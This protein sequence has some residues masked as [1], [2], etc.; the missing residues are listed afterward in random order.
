MFYRIGSADEYLYH[1][2]SAEKLLKYILPSRSLRMG[3]FAS[4]ND[5]RETKD[6]VFGFGRRAGPLDIEEIRKLGSA[7][8]KAAKS[9]AKVICFVRDASGGVGMEPNA[10]YERGFCRPRMW[11][12]YAQNHTGACLV[13]DSKMLRQALAESVSNPRDLFEQHV[14]YLNRSR[15]PSLTD[16]P[17]ILD[18][19]AIRRRGVRDSVRAHIDRHWQALFFEKMMDWSDEREHRWM[20]WEADSEAHYFGFQNAL[21]GIVLGTDFPTESMNKVLAF[22]EQYNVA[23]V[24]QIHWTNGVPQILLLSP[25]R[26]SSKRRSLMDVVRSLLSRGG[27]K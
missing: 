22:Q 26:A 17:F 24:G 20:L 13:F 6:W 2:T 21:V 12:Q 16:N 18:I 14:T 1:Y 27:R 3:P 15:A 25:T 23:R 5:P 19:D 4:T 7:A 11:A 10:I 9:K 8:T